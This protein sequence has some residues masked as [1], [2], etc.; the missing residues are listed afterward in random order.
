LPESAKTKHKQRTREIMDYSM[1][2]SKD[3]GKTLLL[4]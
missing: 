4:L 3:S 1:Q 2:G